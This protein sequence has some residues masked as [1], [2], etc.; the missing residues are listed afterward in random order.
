MWLTL[1]YLCMWSVLSA[2]HAAFLDNACSSTVNLLSSCT[3]L[4]H[5]DQEGQRETRFLLEKGDNIWV[6]K[7]RDQKQSWSF[8]SMKNQNKKFKAKFG[9]IY[10]CFAWRQLKIWESISSRDSKLS[11]TF[12][13]HVQP[14]QRESLKLPIR[15]ETKY[16]YSSDRQTDRQTKQDTTGA[17][18]AFS[19][20]T[21]MTLTSC[22]GLFYFIHESWKAAILV[23]SCFVFP[24]KKKVLSADGI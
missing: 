6:K 3:V 7:P 14:L 17:A 11:N 21:T 10:R 1:Q 20:S 24:C 15:N 19:T 23:A 16:Y 22:A 4:Y 9:A 18:P 2:K 13:V 5:R 8:K 12:D